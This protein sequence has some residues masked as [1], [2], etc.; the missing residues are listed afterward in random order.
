MDLP[1][2][3]KSGFGTSSDSGRKRVPREGPP[4]YEENGDQSIDNMRSERL[5]LPR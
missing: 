3:G 4:T 2:T 1:P 5:D